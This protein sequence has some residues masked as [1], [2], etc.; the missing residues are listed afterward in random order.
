MKT[1]AELEKAYVRKVLQRTNSFQE[2]ATVLGLDIAK[3]YRY[4]RRYGFLNMYSWNHPANNRM[5]P[6]EEILACI[7]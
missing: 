5:T 2:A 3:L 6:D 4:R 7:T 1:L